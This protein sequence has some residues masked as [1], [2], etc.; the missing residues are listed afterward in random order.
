PYLVLQ[1]AAGGSLAD[2]LK[3]GVL[4]PE[5]ARELARQLADALAHVHA[6]GIV[7]R[8]LKPDN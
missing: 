6:A 7:H 8:D 3:R 2:R 4:P 5:D 1:L